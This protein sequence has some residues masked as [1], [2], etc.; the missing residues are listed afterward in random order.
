MGPWF[1][2]DEK[3]PFRPGCSY[4]MLRELVRRGKVTAETVIRGP[5]SRQLW[6]FAGRTPGVSHLLG[7]CHNCRGVASA[8]QSACASC[9]ASFEVSEDRQH[10][11]LAPVHAL[12]G[13]VSADRIADAIAASSPRA[14]VP[15][16]P[17]PPPTP[18]TTPLAAAP[19]AAPMIETRSAV[20]PPTPQTPE[21]RSDGGGL[22]PRHARL[23]VMAVGV[24]GVVSV[25]GAVLLARS[26]WRGGEGSKIAT[27]TSETV[28][29]ASMFSPPAAPIAPARDVAAGPAPAPAVSDGGVRVASDAQREPMPS[30]VV[31]EDARAS[32]EP[33]VASPPMSE[34]RPA[35]QEP[36]PAVE[37]PPVAPPTID[38]RR[39]LMAMVASGRDE[40]ALLTWLQ[41]H[42]DAHP[43]DAAAVGAVREAIR[44]RVRQRR[45]AVLP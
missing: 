23:A 25:V 26:V 31:A 10:L 44:A 11:G 29:P 14:P 43:A 41:A 42:A 40:A 36:V 39:E 32:I 35:A 1:I 6:S 2:R 19:P 34:R 20:T 9:G 33:P 27:R 3:Q 37:A 22:P 28:P 8:E 5:G 45:A 38:W 18:A 30:V 17:M 16:T 12:P 15:A 24:L 21:R 7:M 4:E 13:Q